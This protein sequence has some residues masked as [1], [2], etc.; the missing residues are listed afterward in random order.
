MNPTIPSK[1]LLFNLLSWLNVHACHPYHDHRTRKLTTGKAV[2]LL[3]EAILHQRTSLESVAEHLRA[4]PWLQKWLGLESVDQ[5]TLSRK[6]N[7]LPTM[8]LIELYAQLVRTVCQPYAD[9]MG[10][11]RLGLLAA[12]DSTSI[13]LGATRGTW[14]YMQ[15][16]KN[17]IKVHTCLG[18]TDQSS[19]CPLNVVLSTACIDD[20]DEAVL[21]QLVQDKRYTYLLDRGYIDVDQFLKWNK[22]GIRFAVRLQARNHAKV[23]RRLT[24]RPKAPILLDAEVEV[25]HWRSHESDVFRLVEY[26]YL[27]KKGKRKLVRVL[28]NRYDVSPEDIAQMYKLRWKVE[29]FFKQMKQQ[30]NLRKLFSNKETAVWNHV[31]L[32]LIAYTICELIRT[33]LAP[34]KTVGMVAR[35]IQ[36]YV[37]HSPVQWLTALQRAPTRT[38]KGRQKCHRNGSEQ[39]PLKPRHERIMVFNN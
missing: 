23:L 14:A 6:L 13:T 31:L 28:T 1:V 21:E 10:I 3:L 16:H 8:W 33:T 35:M 2:V 22:E 24:E 5:S 37:D 19:S 15:R 12:V 32:C 39:R 20:R 18:I 27:D 34:K 7:H 36:Q 29:T 30:F 25:K 11:Q 38:S 17:A 4:T 9:R 26:T